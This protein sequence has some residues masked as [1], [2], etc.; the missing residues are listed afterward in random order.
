MQENDSTQ[1][2][3]QALAVQQQQGQLELQDKQEERAHDFKKEVLKSETNI[4]V[5]Y[6]KEDG[7]QGNENDPTEQLLAI[8][9]LKLDQ[10]SVKEDYELKNKDLKETIRHNKATEVIDKK[11]AVQ[12]PAPKKQ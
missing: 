6:I 3:E 4:A 5:A 12:K 11:K 9:K 2:Q 10:K 1:Q 8:E 7:N